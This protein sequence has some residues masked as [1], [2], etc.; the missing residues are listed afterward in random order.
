[1]YTVAIKSGTN[2]YYDMDGCDWIIAEI[3]STNI[4]HVEDILEFGDKENMNRKRYLVRE[5]KR[6]YNFKNAKH[7][8]GEWI[9]VYVINA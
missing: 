5:V 4:P 8:Y 6:M 9:Y 7:E 1:M 3:P 2:D